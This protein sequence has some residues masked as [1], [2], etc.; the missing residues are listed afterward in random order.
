[1]VIKMAWGIPENKPKANP[2]VDRDIQCDDRTFGKQTETKATETNLD[3]VTTKR[4]KNYI[5]L[6][7]GNSGSGKTYTSL[8][9]PKPLIIIDTEARADIIK[10]ECFNSEDIKIFNPIVLPTELNEKGEIIDYKSSIDRLTGFLLSLIGEVKAGN[11]TLKTLVFDS[12]SDLW[13]LAINWGVFKLCDKVT[14]EGK[15]KSDPDTLKFNNQMD[16]FL[17]KNKHHNLFLLM[18]QLTNYGIDIVLTARQKETPEYAKEEK[19]KTMGSLYTETFEERIRCEKNLPFNV[20][21]IA[22]QTLT[23]QNKRLSIIEKSFRKG[24]ED[25]IIED[26]TYEKILEILK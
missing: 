25:K 21:I 24:T 5:Y 3:F 23:N 4:R 9:F 7:Y 8:T 22:R 1:M 12:M 20:D 16:W 2:L 18:K 6:L 13:N 26:M 14:K 15:F 10:D 11:I 17:P 19:K